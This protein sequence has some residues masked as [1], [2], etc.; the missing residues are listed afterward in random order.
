MKWKNW[1]VLPVMAIALLQLFSGCTAIG[2]GVGYLVD[3]AGAE[4]VSYP[5]AKAASQLDT[6]D[7]LVVVLKD[8]TSKHGSF[9]GVIA[10]TEDEMLVEAD[11]SVPDGCVADAPLWPGD[12]ITLQFQSS[13]PVEAI[14][15][16]A[17]PE[18][19]YYRT[20]G[21]RRV[22]GA[23]Y[24]DIKS[25]TFCDGGILSADFASQ[26]LNRNFESVFDVRLR[27]GEKI[28]MFPS[29]AIDH[30]KLDEKS[31]KYRQMFAAGGL[32]V[33]G[34]ILL[35]ALGLEPDDSEEEE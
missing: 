3:S 28:L 7:D 27:D 8:G 14:Y 30:I 10:L 23:R 16:N 33:D 6:G 32:V 13:D 1:T 20:P 31:F 17:D 24:W 25:I 35:N 18:R 29:P 5:P 19:L 9:D 22:V 12:T 11:S 4:I 21:T 15:L 26:Y 34:F 2:Y